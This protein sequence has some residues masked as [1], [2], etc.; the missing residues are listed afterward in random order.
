MI[1]KKL[2]VDKSIVTE[3]INKA[4]KLYPDLDINE[5]NV[6]DIMLM[7]EE[8]D[9]CKSCNDLRCCKNYNKG[10]YTTVVNNEFK[11]AKCKFKEVESK[12]MQARSV[13]K[14]LYMPE[15]IINASF[16]NYDLNSESRM[17]IFNY[18]L[19]F[20]KNF[21]S[22]K[23][24]YI[25][26]TF[27]KGK[28]YTL[29]AI[30]NELGKAGIKSLLIYFPDLVIDLK[31]SL[32]DSIRYNKL[33]NML[34]DIDVLLLDDL[35]SENMTPWLRDD[36]LGPIINYRLMDNKPIFY[37]SNIKPTDL[38]KHFMASPADE[39]KADRIISRLNSM[40]NSVSMDDC[41]KYER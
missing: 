18:T 31:S 11:L 21:G 29:G 8:Q 6:N 17:K 33:I 37:S 27:S 40:V 23:G 34:K 13:I 2:N 3:Y 4:K 15:R 30:A 22:K 19:D 16:E 20:I 36:I 32:N 7:K 39:L 9:N 35:G 1:N 38:K 10:Y 5:F 41:Q 25:Y 12:K 28:T 26:S 14:T 24:L